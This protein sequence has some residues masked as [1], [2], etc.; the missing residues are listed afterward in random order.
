MQNTVINPNKRFIVLVYGIFKMSRP[1]QL[2]AIILVYLYGS[3][4]AW[5]HNANVNLSTFGYGLLV[6]LLVSASI[7]FANEYADYENDAL[8][9]RTPYSGGSGALQD[10]GLHPRVA[11]ISAWLALLI[12][13]IMAV[14]G[15]FLGLMTTITL[16]VLFVGAFLGWM[17]SLPPLA[18]AWRGWGELDNA[19][20]GGV[21]LPLYGYLVQSGELDPVMVL[22]FIPF[23]MLA[24]D[25][26]LATTWAD[27][28]ADRSVGKFTLATRWSTSRLRFLY[29]AVAVGAFVYLGI[30]NQLLYPQ[31]VFLA[32]FLVVPVV[33]WGFVAYTRQNSPFPSVAAMVVFLLIQVAAWGAILL[34]V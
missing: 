16:V 4:V 3:V 24:F 14:L 20:L 18:L 15:Y 8:T 25:N 2:L 21:A 34:W 17:Y 6:V 9:R 7:H 22:I 10:L 32:S 5:V 19:L 11:L 1:A 12:G 23:S 27:R 13:G 31:W 26:L 28:D 29:L 33:L 30:F